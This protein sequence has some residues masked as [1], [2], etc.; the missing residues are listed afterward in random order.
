MNDIE[1][2]GVT[3]VGVDARSITVSLPTAF[4]NTNYSVILG[5]NNFNGN[6]TAHC[7]EYASSKTNT[8]FN[9][10]CTFTYKTEGNTGVSWYACGY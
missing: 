1:Q 3:T 8:A 5:K 6:S 10:K 7:Q 2:W 9:V 4:S